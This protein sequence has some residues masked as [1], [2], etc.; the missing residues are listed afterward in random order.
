MKDYNEKAAILAVKYAVNVKPGD[1]VI[2]QGSEVANDLI[3]AVYIEI[4]KQEDI[5]SP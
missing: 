5:L 4:L 1:L 3:K 2:I